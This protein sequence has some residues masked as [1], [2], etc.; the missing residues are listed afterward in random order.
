M[1]IQV[2]TASFALSPKSASPKSASPKRS[3]SPPASP[4]SDPSEVGELK[5]RLSSCRG[6]DF[7]VFDTGAMLSLCPWAAT[8]D[9]IRYAARVAESHGDY[10]AIDWLIHV[11]GNP[12]WYECAMMPAAIC[13]ATATVAHLLSAPE[14]WCPGALRP[15]TEEEEEEEEEADEAPRKRRKV[16]SPRRR[17]RKNNNNNN[18]AAARAA[19]AIVSKK[20]QPAPS[21][22][23]LMLHS[24]LSG[25]LAVVKELARRFEADAVRIAG[26]WRDG[27]AGVPRV[28]GP[29]SDPA[30]DSP[31]VYLGCVEIKLGSHAYYAPRHADYDLVV[32]SIEWANR[33]AD[34]QIKRTL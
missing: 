23:L 34:C 28:R 27:R 19:A 9:A 5:R 31:T 30:V 6:G 2:Q 26:T 22:A 7:S 21:P 25:R 1:K 29:F 16:E 3:P 12:H 24:V 10:T 15:T 8:R 18:A 11:A 14:L 33:A 17:S 20:K 32:R 13:G 4:E